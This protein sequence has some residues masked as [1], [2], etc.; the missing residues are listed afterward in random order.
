MNLNM[1]Q[2][3][4]KTED[5]LLSITKNCETFLKKLLQNY[6]KHSNSGLT[7]QEKLF[8]LLHLSRLKDHG[9]SD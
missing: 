4:N 1:I 8:V 7:N 3:R 2:P 5:L 9:C 6:K